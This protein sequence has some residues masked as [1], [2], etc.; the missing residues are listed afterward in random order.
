MRGSRH[1][2]GI[3]AKSLHLIHKP[4]A[5]REKWVGR[6]RERQRSRRGRK[7]H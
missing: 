6:E 1:G 3:V 2:V 4:N 7:E 5:K